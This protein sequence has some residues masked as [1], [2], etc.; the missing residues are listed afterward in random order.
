[1]VYAS[2]FNESFIENLDRY[3]IKVAFLQTKSANERILSSISKFRSAPITV[4][5]DQE[6]NELVKSFGLEPVMA[7]GSL[8][9]TLLASIEG[10]ARAP[11]QEYRKKGFSDE[12]LVAIRAVDLH[13]D[14]FSFRESSVNPFPVSDI[15]LFRPNEILINDLRHRNAPSVSP[16][17]LPE[18]RLKTLLWLS[19]IVQG[20]K[21]VDYL[22]YQAEQSPDPDLS[23][24]LA[25][26]LSEYMRS[27]S[28]SNYETLLQKAIKLLPIFPGATDYMLCCPSIN[29][30]YAFESLSRLVPSRILRLVLRRTSNDYIDTHAETDFRSK[31]DYEQYLVLATFLTLENDFLSNV[32]TL[33]SL[34]SRRPGP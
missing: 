11:L 28:S 7:D 21:L 8:Q 2:S 6:T 22:A 23:P 5:E 14:L 13:P 20:Q 9:A 27:Q 12:D 16:E 17:A 19:K 26:A 33:H 32:L 31:Q 30:R 24:D 25:L 18:E 15:R 34:A 1:L 10:L 4:V 29:P 3:P